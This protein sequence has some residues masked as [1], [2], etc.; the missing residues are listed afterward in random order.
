MEQ[1]AITVSTETP[2]QRPQILIS[3]GSISFQVRQVTQ[4]PLD[5][6][7]KHINKRYISPRSKKERSKKFSQGKSKETSQ[8]RKGIDKRYFEYIKHNESLNFYDSNKNSTLKGINIS[9]NEVDGRNKTTSKP[10]YGTENMSHIIALLN[11]KKHYRSNN[12]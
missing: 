2:S 12:K 3:Q 6:Q 4:N 8:N 11:D 5:S 9:I 7:I 10:Q 1:Q